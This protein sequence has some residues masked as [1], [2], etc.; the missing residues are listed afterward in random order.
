MAKYDKNGFIEELGRGEDNVGCGWG[1]WE[2]F[3]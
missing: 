2:G 1:L 3:M